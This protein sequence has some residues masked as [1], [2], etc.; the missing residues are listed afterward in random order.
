MTDELE[1]TVTILAVEDEAPIRNMI[2]RLLTERGYTVIAAASGEEAIEMVGEQP[3]SML[4]TDVKMRGMSGRELAERLERT[5]YPLRVLYIS[6]HTQEQL[7]FEEGVEISYLQKPFM[8]RELLEQVAAV[9][10]R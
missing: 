2:T 9:L 6:G 10:A 7:G 8:P 5:H 3:I 1:P 4:L